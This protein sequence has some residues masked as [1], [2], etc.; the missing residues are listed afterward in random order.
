MRDGVAAINYFID[1][2]ARP[3]IVKRWSRDAKGFEHLIQTRAPDIAK[4]IEKCLLVNASR[5]CRK[6]TR[7]E[8]RTSLP[9][10]P[11]AWGRYRFKL[12]IKCER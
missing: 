4:L 5:I 10:G 2:L 1:V 9:L 6:R 7:E 12:R 3:R 11:A 8:S